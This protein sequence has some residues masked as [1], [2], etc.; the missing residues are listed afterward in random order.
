MSPWDCQCQ[1]LH[2]VPVGI[3]LLRNQQLRLGLPDLNTIRHDCQL[4][5]GKSGLAI[6]E[7]REN[8]GEQDSAQTPLSCAGAERQRTASNPCQGR[9][10]LRLNVCH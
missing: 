10:A 2:R 7:G 6:R 5:M 1:P 8:G 4:A 9:L 3:I